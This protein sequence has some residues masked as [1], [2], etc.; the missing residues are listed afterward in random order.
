M[1]KVE[2]EER[3]ERVQKWFNMGRTQ[4]WIARR[5]GVSQPMISKIIRGNLERHA[6]PATA[7]QV[8]EYILTQLEAYRQDIENAYRGW[9]ASMKPKEREEMGI[10]LG[11][12][13][14]GELE[15]IKRVTEGQSGN[16]GYINAILK[17]RRDR[18][19]LLGFVKNVQINNQNSNTNVNKSE[20]GLEK[21]L[22]EAPDAIE[23][24][25]RLS[26]EMPDR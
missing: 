16:P 21:V 20:A 6:V 19:E 12:D 23:E 22:D 5:E 13:A 24:R 1:T 18:N 17:A 11:D 8:R 25:I 10:R 14:P 3:R 9:V 4:S 26:Q 15:I 2:F 7:E